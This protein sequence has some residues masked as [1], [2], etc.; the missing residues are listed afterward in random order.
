MLFEYGA[1]HL[2]HEESRNL[3]VATLV[4]DGWSGEDRAP[5]LAA[6]HRVG[7]GTS[8]PEVNILSLAKNEQSSLMSNCVT[9]ISVLE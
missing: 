8:T 3:S 7:L 6:Q 5:W 9:H 1:L 4:F 2:F